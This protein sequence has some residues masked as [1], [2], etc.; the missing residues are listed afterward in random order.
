LNVWLRGF[1]DDPIL[2]ITGAAG[3]KKLFDFDETRVA[4]YQY[5]P[6]G[7]KGSPYIYIDNAS[8]GLVP[9]DVA[10]LSSAGAQRVPI[11]PPPT[12]TAQDFGTA[13]PVP[14]SPAPQ[15]FFN[16]DTFQILCAGQDET[17]GTDDDLSNFWKGTR[18]QY[19]ES[20]SQ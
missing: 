8:Y 18:K 3:R 16:P 11:S 12:A 6:A 9:Y 1:T 14:T 17:F 20:F 7:K 15:P 4:N 19:F 5:S 2:P 10:N 13:V